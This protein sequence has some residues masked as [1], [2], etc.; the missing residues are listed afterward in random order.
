MTFV[1]FLTEL[2]YLIDTELEALHRTLRRRGPAPR[3]CDSEV[4]TMELAGEFQ[5]IDTDEGI[6][7]FFRTYHLAEFPRMAQVDRTRFLR[8]AA[9][10]WKVKQWLHARVLRHFPRD[11]GGEPDTTNPVPLWVIDSFPLRVCKFKRAPSHKLF[12]GQ[13]A[14]GHDPTAGSDLPGGR[15]G[16]MYGFHVHLRT[17]AEGLCLQWE[18][19]PANVH[20][21]PLVRE[22]LPTPMPAAGAVAVADRHYWNPAGR[23]ELL[24]LGLDLIAP[25]S[26]QKHDPWPLVSKLISRLRQIIEPVIGQLATRFHIQRTWARDLWHLTSRL[27]RK[28]LSHTAACLINWRHGNPMLQLDKLIT[29]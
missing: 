26:K 3:L 11:P 29:A 27:T 10:L 13:A 28:V 24:A 20:D 15:R 17:D 14:Y 22:L 23:R 4:I 25:F 1:D 18:L 12:R 19:A 16:M 2:F 8:Q 6:W 9:N 7:A 5:G 21:G